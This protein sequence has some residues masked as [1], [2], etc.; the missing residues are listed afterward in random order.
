MFCPVERGVVV[1][2]KPY[3]KMARK[4][5]AKPRRRGNQ[6]DV[7][8]RRR[9][10][11]RFA[12]DASNSSDE[13]YVFDE[14][15]EDDDDEGFSSEVNESDEEEEAQSTSSED[16]EE[17]SDAASE[18]LSDAGKSRKPRPVN[19]KS[20]GKAPTLKGN[21]R[22][23]ATK[24]VKISSSDDE[25]FEPDLS[26]TTDDDEYDEDSEEEETAVVRKSRQKTKRVTKS[27]RSGTRKPKTKKKRAS[28]SKRSVRKKKKR[29]TASQKSASKRRKT[30]A[31]SHIS[32]RNVDRSDSVSDAYFVKP[33]KRARSQRKSSRNEESEWSADSL[34]DEHFVIPTKRARSQRKSTRNEEIGWRSTRRRKSI[35]EPEF[36]CSESNADYAISEEDSEPSYRSH[37]CTKTASLSMRSLSIEKQEIVS[38]GKDQ[39]K[40][41]TSLLEGK[42]KKEEGWRRKGKQ[43]AEESEHAVDSEFSK[44]VCGICLS[45][46]GKPS[47]GKLDCCDHYF[48]FAC[49]M[50]WAK[51]ESRCPMCK[52]RFRTISKSSKSGKGLRGTTIKIPV[53][54]QVY[55]PS[56]EE[57]MGFLDPYANIVCLDCNEAGDDDLLLLCDRCDS[58][59]HTYCVG[60]G[61][62]IPEGDWYCQ[63]CQTSMPGQSS[64]HDE[65]VEDFVL[66][67][68]NGDEGLGIRGFVEDAPVGMV[69]ERINLDLN[70]SP[71]SSSS[72]PLVET[73]PTHV[74]TIRRRILR[75]STPNPSP[76]LPDAARVSLRQTEVSGSTSQV[77]SV[78]ARTLSGQRILQERVQALHDNWSAPERGFQ[79]FSPSSSLDRF[80]VRDGTDAIVQ[81]T[82]NSRSLLFRESA[83]RSN[84]APVLEMENDAV[85]SDVDQAWA[86][87]ECALASRED[88]MGPANSQKDGRHWQ[89]STSGHKKN[90]LSELMGN[91]RSSVVSGSILTAPVRSRTSNSQDRHSPATANYL[92]NPERITEEI[93]YRDIGNNRLPV[94][95]VSNEILGIRLSE[96]S[97]SLHHQLNNGTSFSKPH[98]NGGRKVEGAK[99]KVISMVKSHMKRTLTREHIEK[100]LFKEIARCCTHTILAACGIE[101]SRSRVQPFEVVSCRHTDRVH[102]CSELMP[103]C[104]T[105]C[106]N[107]FVK[108]LVAGI[109][110]RKVET[111]IA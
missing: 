29:S 55:Q 97:N 106:F 20:N 77:S 63:G 41:Y 18:E 50:E 23:R 24:R 70:L 5:R 105:D 21:P 78:R 110:D 100:D 94:P 102:Q 104:C 88:N 1:I 2:L 64:T 49:I 44:P 12:E 33:P 99:E 69:A 95:S 75:R 22:N 54:N 42:L 74:R 36:S 80:G 43:K 47:R 67:F 93:S 83:R 16:S 38:Y 92:E 96:R 10:K 111:I 59:Y 51:V 79:Q 101:H 65:D 71:P 52:Q 34:S 61:R 107:S 76:R 3:S 103:G 7:R 66:D 60:L 98:E 19:S 72:A 87:M 13:D 84:L 14:E 73:R 90:D 27:K 58:A 28:V 86:M 37:G 15:E 32:V 81:P 57:V 17:L 56:E 53:R 68:D 46:D 25:D 31:A 45:E 30:T 6:E 85:K 35:P 39:Q 9:G 108:E 4:F 109:V 91:A 40:K 8:R 26:S 82:P 11:R 89:G 62:A 48:C